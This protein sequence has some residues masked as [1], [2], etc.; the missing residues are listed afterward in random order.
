MHLKEG[1]SLTA[2]L[3]LVAAGVHQDTGWVEDAGVKCDG[4]LVLTDSS[5]RTSAPDV[6]AAGDIACPQRR[7]GT[8]AQGRA[9]GRRR[10]HGRVAGATAA[11]ADDELGSGRPAS[12]ARSVTGP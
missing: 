12:G 10:T 6:Y 2:D 1:P 7:G 8:A 11:G 3:V 9:L 4:G 5:M